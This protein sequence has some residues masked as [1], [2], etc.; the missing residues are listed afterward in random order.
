MHWLVSSRS[1]KAVT[2]ISL[3]SD[4]QCSCLASNSKKQ[5]WASQESNTE[6]VLNWVRDVRFA[7]TPA[8]KG[9]S[10]LTSGSPENSPPP[11]QQRPQLPCSAVSHAHTNTGVYN[12][13]SALATANTHSQGA[14]LY[15]PSLT[16]ETPRQHSIVMDIRGPVCVGL[17]EKMG[18]GRVPLWSCWRDLGL[19]GPAVGSLPHWAKVSGYPKLEKP[20]FK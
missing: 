2:P 1:N 18:E 12:R 4:Y 6:G 9:P 8:W 11:P 20:H 13:G 3:I 7:V 17:L 19:F 10:A 14:P 15:I 5:V 16:M